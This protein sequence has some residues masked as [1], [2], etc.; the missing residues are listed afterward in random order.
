MTRI[1][2]QNIFR[3]QWN[4]ERFPRPDPAHRP[5]SAYIISCGRTEF[6]YSRFPST[7]SPHCTF[8]VFRHEAYRRQCIAFMLA[9][10]RFLVLVYR[11]YSSSM[12][13]PWKKWRLSAQPRTQGVWDMKREGA[14]AQLPIYDI[15]KTFWWFLSGRRYWNTKMRILWC[16]F[17]RT[18]RGFLSFMQ[19]TTTLE[20]LISGVRAQR[21]D[22]IVIFISKF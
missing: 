17:F 11:Q 9:G 16:V 6:A 10:L 14:V 12:N 19:Q 18:L 3:E 4:L 7:K 2:P 15:I 21:A 13:I 8:L 22:T 1:T 5:I 20:P